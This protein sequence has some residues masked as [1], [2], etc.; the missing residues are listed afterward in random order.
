MS[1][2]SFILELSDLNFVNQAIEEHGSDLAGATAVAVA[3]KEDA[4]EMVDPSEPT[5]TTMADS[6]ERT[7][8]TTGRVNVARGGPA[9]QATQ[10]RSGNGGRGRFGER[11]RPRPLRRR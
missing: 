10:A 4:P 11:H 9:G 3:M 6:T 7:A 8:D 1:E 2:G 5:S